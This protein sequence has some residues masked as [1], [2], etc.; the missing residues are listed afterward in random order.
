MASQLIRFPICL[1]NSGSLSKDTEKKSAAQG[2]SP[3]LEI[4]SSLDDRGLPLDATRLYLREIGNAKLLTAEEE[5]QLSR[6]AQKGDEA[7]RQRM[8]ANNLRL[9]V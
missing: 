8:I 4:S 3:G 2:D 5:V 9:V 7:A 1:E 6:R